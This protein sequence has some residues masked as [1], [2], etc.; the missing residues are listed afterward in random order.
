MIYGYHQQNPLWLAYAEWKFLR[1][2]SGN[3]IKRRLNELPEPR[4]AK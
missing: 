1:K 4:E 2:V 3:G